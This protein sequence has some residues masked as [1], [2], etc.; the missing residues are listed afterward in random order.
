MPRSCHA[1]RKEYTKTVCFRISL[2]NFGACS[3]DSPLR[4]AFVAQRSSLSFS[5]THTRD[6]NTRI[7]HTWKMCFSKRRTSYNNSTNTILF[8]VKSLWFQA[9][10]HARVQATFHFSTEGNRSTVNG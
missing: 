4:H 1:L 9:L 6:K 5:L 7:P 10:R 8:A 2:Y 3:G